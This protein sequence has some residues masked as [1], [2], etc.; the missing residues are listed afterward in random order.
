MSD[1]N[2]LLVI[3]VLLSVGFSAVMLLLLAIFEKL[4][5]ITKGRKGEGS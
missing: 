3:I 4:C 2:L 1:A 5:E